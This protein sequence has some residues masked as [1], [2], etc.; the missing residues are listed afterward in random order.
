M[1]DI[2]DFGQ[3]MD[4]KRYSPQTKASYSNAVKLLSHHY[5]DISLESISDKQ[6][7]QFIL[8]LIREKEISASYQRQI[9]GGL[10]LFYKE[11]YQR[12]LN[13]TQL[14]VTRRESA[15]PQ[16]LDKAEITALLHKTHNIKHRAMLTLLYSSGLRVGELI[17]V[18]INHIDSKRMVIYVKAA[19]GKK[20]RYTLLSIKALHLLREYVKQHKPK[21]FLFEGQKGGK[22]SANSVRQIFKASCKR[23]NIR[24]NVNLHSLRHSFATHL[25]EQGTGIAHIQKLLGHAN[26][27]TTLIYT[28]ITTANLSTIISPLDSL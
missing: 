5:S 26:I 22:Y 2:V 9:V 23:A 10:N 14:A 16:V 13:V 11:M 24:K 19:K 27:K 1:Q 4:I 12:H 17:N 6:I 3:I 28:Q 20:D 18:K 15:L 7:Q 8:T 25:L 21:D